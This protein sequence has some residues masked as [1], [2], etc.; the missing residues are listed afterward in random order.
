MYNNNKNDCQFKSQH[1]TQQFFLTHTI[2]T[3]KYA[4]NHHLSGIS[5]NHPFSVASVT[6]ISTTF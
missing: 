6:A 1:L 2:Q 4:D 3:K 5:Y